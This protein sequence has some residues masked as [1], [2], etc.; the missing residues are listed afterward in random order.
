MLA[1]DLASGEAWL[2][3]AGS[4]LLATLWTNLAWLF[5]PWVE[6]GRSAND[7]ESLAER[8]VVQLASWRFAGTLFQGLRLL[9]HVALPF[10]ALFWGHDAVI[11]RFF[12]LQRLTLPVAG[13]L[14][15]GVSTNANWLDWSQDIGWAAAL[16]LGSWAMLL[17]AGWVRR[18]ALARAGES[19][20]T[21]R[22]PGW[23]TLREALYHETHWAFYRNA[24]IV[25]LGVYWGTW[26]GLALSALEAVLNPTW[27]RG[28][29]T[30]GRAAPLVL[31]AALAVISSLL[32]LRTQ[33]LW[34]GILIHWGVASG[35]RTLYP[36]P[37]SLTPEGAGTE[38]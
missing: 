8:I 36:A 12:G 27:R 25:T 34:L 10:A 37:S 23:E 19:H 28:L 31:R 7:S 2:W 16:G 33:N 29:S 9:Y 24:P 3:L 21:S 1:F 5:S 18:Q 22:T 17:A 11:S 30:P 26:A 6:A 13:A 4:L 35:L 15:E 38:V 32:F 20:S 14:A